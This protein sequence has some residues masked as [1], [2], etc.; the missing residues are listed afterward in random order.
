MREKVCRRKADRESEK[1][2]TAESCCCFSRLS[3][4]LQME[5]NVKHSL[6]LASGGIN[7]LE[8]DSA[9]REVNACLSVSSTFPPALTHCTFQNAPAAF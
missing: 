1:S 7:S 9:G 6:L 2:D 3:L 4:S 8:W 5:V